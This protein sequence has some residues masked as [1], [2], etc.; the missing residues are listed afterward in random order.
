MPVILEV[1]TIGETKNKDALFIKIKDVSF[2]FRSV[3]NYLHNDQNVHT[4][5]TFSLY[6]ITSS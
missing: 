5:I 3:I 4:L 6:S 2:W 1:I